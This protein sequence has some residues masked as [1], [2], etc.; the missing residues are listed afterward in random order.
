MNQKNKIAIWILA[1]TSIIILF[2]N[3]ILKF[4]TEALFQFKE[5]KVTSY[6]MENSLFYSVIT[7]EANEYCLNK[8][9][10]M[11]YVTKSEILAYSDIYKLDKCISELNSDRK[12]SFK[13]KTD[14]YKDTRF[15]FLIF[16]KEDNKIISKGFVNSINGKFSSYIGTS[17]SSRTIYSICIL[18]GSYSNCSNN[19]YQALFK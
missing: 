12:I 10:N 14:C 13:G 4:K 2:T 6:S 7:N 11:Y 16:R 9:S 3:P 19:K 18:D 17:V 1:F 8:L 15:E 5:C